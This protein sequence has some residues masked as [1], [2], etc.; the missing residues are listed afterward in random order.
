MT[1]FSCFSG[2][3]RYCHSVCGKVQRDVLPLF[4]LL[5]RCSN[6]RVSIDGPEAWVFPRSY[7]ICFDF[8]LPELLHVLPWLMQSFW[9]PDQQHCCGKNRVP[10]GTVSN[11]IFSFSFLIFSWFF[12]DFFDLGCSHNCILTNAVFV[13]GPSANSFLLVDN[14]LLSLRVSCV[15]LV[16][17][18]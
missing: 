9:R 2:R 5:R 18:I 7:D 10:F 8:V 11:V 15:L 4:L 13:S 17:S 6:K 3:T 16:L 1:N 12:L 14:S